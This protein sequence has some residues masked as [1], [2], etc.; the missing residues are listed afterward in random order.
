[1]SLFADMLD[2]PQA[3]LRDRVQEAEALAGAANA[4]AGQFVSE[5]RAFV[6]ETP[7]G[8]LQEI[9]TGTFDLDAACHP[10]VGYHMF[11][12]TYK[13]S[14]FL[15]GLKERYRAHNFAAPANELPD[16]LAVVLRFLAVCDDEELSRELIDLG[17]RT[18]LEKMTGDVDP[19]ALTEEGQEQPEI[20]LGGLRVY[21]QVLRALQ[22]VL[23]VQPQ[24]V[25]ALP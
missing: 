10:Y 17:L 23:Q 8:S 1:M 18:C 7:L 14:P 3:N 9:Y 5:F 24:S 6:E 2:Y 11:G 22:L 25:E 20:N 12:E 21:K 16:H 19:D 4:Q 13:R 15:V